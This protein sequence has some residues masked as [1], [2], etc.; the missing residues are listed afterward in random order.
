MF[1]DDFFFFFAIWMKVHLSV[2]HAC[3]C[4]VVSRFH[5]VGLSRVGVGLKVARRGKAANRGIH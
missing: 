5:G 2:R 3:V 4:V 1:L